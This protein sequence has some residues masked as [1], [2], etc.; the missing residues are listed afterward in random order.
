M[1]L[2]VIKGK[3]GGKLAALVRKMEKMEETGLWLKEW[4]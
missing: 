3:L 1:S 2:L 4:S